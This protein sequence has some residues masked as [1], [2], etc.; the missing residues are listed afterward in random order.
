MK[1]ECEDPSSLRGYYLCVG[2]ARGGN[3]SPA[4]SS[5]CEGS[6]ANAVCFDARPDAAAAAAA[7]EARPECP[8]SGEGR[9]YTVAGAN[10]TFLRSCDTELLGEDLAQ[11]PTL[12]MV[13]CLALCAQLHAGHASALGRC[14]GVTWVYGDGPQGE[15]VSFCYLKTRL[16]ASRRRGGTESGELWLWSEKG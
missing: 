3:A 12:T 14:E 10:L 2:P 13:D 15:G 16:A 9:L 1:I 8:L 7:G 5:S 6:S 11:F 4:A